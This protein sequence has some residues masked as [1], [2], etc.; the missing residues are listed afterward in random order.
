MEHVQFLTSHRGLDH[1]TFGRQ[2]FSLT[3]PFLNFYHPPIQRTLVGTVYFVRVI[4][5]RCL[6]F[7]FSICASCT[8]QFK[9]ERSGCGGQP[10]TATT[11]VC[12]KRIRRVRQGLVELPGPRGPT[13]T[14]LFVDTFC[15]PALPSLSRLF[16]SPRRT[17]EKM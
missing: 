3:P 14:E 5:K 9:M 10:E 13:V 11:V 17:E 15:C 4:Y 1:V 12:D 2:L 6:W 16:S 7:N 8:C